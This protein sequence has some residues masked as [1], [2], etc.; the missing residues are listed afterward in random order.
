MNE[1]G[2]ETPGKTWGKMGLGIVGII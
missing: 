1:C 2:E